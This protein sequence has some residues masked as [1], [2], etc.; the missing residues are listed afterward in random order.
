MVLGEKQQEVGQLRVGQGVAVGQEEVAQLTAG[1]EHH[2]EDADLIMAVRE[3]RSLG[4]RW[5]W[6]PG[7]QEV[8]LPLAKLTQ[9]VQKQGCGPAQR[10]VDP[11]VDLPGPQH[12]ALRQRRHR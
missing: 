7:R 1:S 11:A 12:A 2:A 4:S 8:A 5:W 3:R 9:Q 10:A 6:P